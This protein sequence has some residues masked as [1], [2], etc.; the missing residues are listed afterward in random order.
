[1][2][3]FDFLIFPRND[4]INIDC[5]FDTFDNF[6]EHVSNLSFIPHSLESKKLLYFDS[7]QIISYMVKYI[8]DSRNKNEIVT[9]TSVLKN[10]YNNCF[11]E[12]TTGCNF[13][14]YIVSFPVSE[15]IVET[16]GSVIDRII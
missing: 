16:W 15:A 4:R 9:M 3:D 1:M 7:K 10:A 11:E 13:S 8:T 2:F 5:F 6:I 14:S 12:S